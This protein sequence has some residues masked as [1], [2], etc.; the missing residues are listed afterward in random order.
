MRECEG[1]AGLPPAARLVPGPTQRCRGGFGPPDAL[2][3]LGSTEASL[4]RAP[5][6]GDAKKCR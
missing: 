3:A 6:M 5:T 2:G 1:D 4:D